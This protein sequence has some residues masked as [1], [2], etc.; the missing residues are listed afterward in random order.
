M[1]LWK[2]YLIRKKLDKFIPEDKNEII[3]QR[4]YLNDW[5]IWIYFLT[6]YKPII[7]ACDV[8]MF[9]IC[10]RWIDL[11]ARS[12]R[13]ISMSEQK[14]ILFKSMPQLEEIWL[15]W[16]KQMLRS[17]SSLPDIII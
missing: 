12:E 8:K 15:K 2:E 11:Y 7:S 3:V 16:S 5:Q 13:G 9:R 14:G 6:T 17:R 4:S 10:K 1:E